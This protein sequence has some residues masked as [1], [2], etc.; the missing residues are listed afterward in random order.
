MEELLLYELDKKDSIG[1][2]NSKGQIF[3]N[4]KILSTISLPRILFANIPVILHLSCNI[5]LSPARYS[6]RKTG[7]EGFYPYL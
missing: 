1:M 4:D 7:P 5:T 2:I 3:I 6:S